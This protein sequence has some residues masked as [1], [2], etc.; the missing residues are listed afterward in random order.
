MTEEEEV[1]GNSIHLL[2]GRNKISTLQYWPKW[3]HK[4]ELNIAVEDILDSGLHIPKPWNTEILI[5]KMNENSAGKVDNSEH[6]TAYDVF[7]N[8]RFH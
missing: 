3:E 4:Q 6:Q 1:T 7:L 2:E 8:R 5:Y